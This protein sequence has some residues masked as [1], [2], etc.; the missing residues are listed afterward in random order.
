MQHEKKYLMPKVY[1]SRFDFLLNYCKQKSVLHLGCTSGKFLPDKIQ[2]R[3][4]LHV[5]LNSVTNELYGVDI[6]T[7]SLQIMS[8][9]F[10]ITNLYHGDVERLDKVNID[11][12]FDVI[13]AGD[14]IE[15]LSNPGMMLDGIHRF[16]H[17]DSILI[18][19][20]NNSFSL[21]AFIRFAVGKY[22]E[23]EDHV[24]VFSPYVLYNILERHDFKPIDIYGA[25]TRPAYG[26]KEKVIYF[27]GMPFLK[28]RP[29][30][31]GTIIILAKSNKL[32]LKN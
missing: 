21:P 14:I 9:Y 4:S 10:N 16:M 31:A 29:G 32:K 27:L 26:L 6:H 19:S 13:L 20:T 3:N 1:V 8:E 15:H 12:Q 23:H 5:Y 24:F 28:L 30:T 2:Q 7:S 11:R 18:I 17:Q 22:V 25:Y